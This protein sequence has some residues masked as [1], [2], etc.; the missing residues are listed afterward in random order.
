MSKKILICEKQFEDRM[1]CGNLSKSV[2]YGNDNGAAYS[3]PK[4]AKFRSIPWANCT[5]A[6]RTLTYRLLKE[7][8]N[9]TLSKVER[10]T[11][12][13][14]LEVILSVIVKRNHRTAPSD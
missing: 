13:V 7:M 8:R 2:N 9:P 10:I 1:V 6:T 14:I 12:K 5:I 11:R 3:E 4:L